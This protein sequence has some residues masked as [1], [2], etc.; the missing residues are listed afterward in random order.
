M[1]FFDTDE[2]Y[3]RGLDWYHAQFA[4]CLDHQLIGEFTPSYTY[5]QKTLERIRSGFSDVHLILCI[6]D[7]IER[8]ISQFTQKRQ[9]FVEEAN[10]FS[11]ALTGA[12]RHLY[13]DRSLYGEHL[14]RIIRVFGHE[15]PLHIIRYED[16]KERPEVVAS[17]LYSTLG[18][19]PTY[20][21]SCVSHRV[22]RSC[23]KNERVRAITPVLYRAK[24][25][26]KRWCGSNKHIRRLGMI[27]WRAIMR[28]NRYT[29]TT[30][31]TTPP[32]PPADQ[33]ELEGIF[34]RDRAQFDTLLTKLTNLTRT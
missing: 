20:T 22:N 19:D 3:Q 32:L 6:R 23:P 30:P 16:I 13:V 17:R 10:T 26:G 2:V 25:W 34:Q 14:K 33:R 27:L 4:Q 15:V 12:H 9:K 1:H 18:V 28:T 11:A 31:R 29:A 8:A 7:P 5:N 21:P 24:R